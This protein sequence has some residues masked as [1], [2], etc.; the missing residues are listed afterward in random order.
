LDFKEPTVIDEEWQA[1]ERWALAQRVAAS[2]CFQKSA[3]LREFL[4]YVSERAIRN[5]PEEL[6][7]QQIGTQ[8][9]Q[10]APSYNPSEDN[11][12]RVEARELRKRLELYFATEGAQESLVITIPKGAYVPVFLAREAAAAPLTDAAP[13]LPEDKG[14]VPALVKASRWRGLTQAAQWPLMTAVL[15]GVVLLL[16]GVTWYLWQENRRQQQTLATLQKTPP[17]LSLW[18]R[19][20][21]ADKPPVVAISDIAHVVVRRVTKTNSSLNAYLSRKYLTE[22]TPDLQQFLSSRRWTTLAD[23]KL[24]RRLTELDHTGQMRVVHPWDLQLQ[25]LQTN[26]VILLGGRYSNPW[27]EMFESQRNFKPGYDWQTNRPYYQNSAPQPGE[28]ARY[29]AGSDGGSTDDSYGTITFL[30]NIH[31]TGSILI[32]EGTTSEGLEAAG[33]FFTDA[34]LFA[35][36]EARLQAEKHTAELPY[37]ELLVK[38]NRLNGNA[39]EAIYVTHRILSR[40]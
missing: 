6:R 3:R 9:F 7:E 5:R 38:T 15:A 11:I 39:K 36:F 8:V 23:L 34:R 21:T 28:A 25:D 24:V 27:I 22:L 31:R 13:D 32:I 4:L 16:L 33:D 35:Q 40:T 1:D 26:N 12:V 18:S 30:P 20:F 2:A 14:D 37:F 10:R 19:L 17:P 29:I